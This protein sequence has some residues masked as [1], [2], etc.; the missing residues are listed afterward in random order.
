MLRGM[1][2]WFQ[3]SLVNRGDNCGQSDCLIGTQVS[4]NT[5]HHGIILGHP[6]QDSIDTDSIVFPSS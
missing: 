2:V 3:R 5:G 4:I 1:S 6:K